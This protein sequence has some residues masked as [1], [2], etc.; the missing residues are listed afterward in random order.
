MIKIEIDEEVFAYLQNK[1]IAFVETPNH[2][3]RRLLNISGKK[4]RTR[5]LNI[6]KTKKM[7]KTNLLELIQA[8]LLME[9]Q[10]LFFR[11]YQ[12]NE[13]KEYDVIVSD[14]SLI[15]NDTAYSMSELAKIL[16]KNHGYES[17]SVRGPLFWYTQNGVSIK[18]L[19]EKYNKS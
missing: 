9:N 7:R 15:W 4:S 12:G 2:T 13:Y 6:H 8:G 19:W 5:S 17:D 16:L 11:D 10:R 3:L 1:A 14:N 18:D